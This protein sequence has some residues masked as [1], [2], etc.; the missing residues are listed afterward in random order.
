MLSL[1]SGTFLGDASNAS[2]DTPGTPQA[3]SDCQ[4]V[5]NDFASLKTEL[6]SNA[7]GSGIKGLP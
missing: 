3:V 1:S 4:A 2:N 7:P 5:L 6:A